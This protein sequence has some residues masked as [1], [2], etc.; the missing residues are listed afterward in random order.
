MK[1][2]S[3][4]NWLFEKV[5][6]TITPTEKTDCVKAFKIME[7]VKPSEI[8]KGSIGDNCALTHIANGFGEPHPYD[9]PMAQLRVNNLYLFNANDEQSED[10]PQET[11]KERVLAWLNDAINLGY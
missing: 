6:T 1:I 11:P 3:L 4:L 2:K 10:Y 5:I 9:L 7:A 8:G